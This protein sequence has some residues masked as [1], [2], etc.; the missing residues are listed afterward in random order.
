[1][2]RKWFS[3]IVVMLIVLITLVGCGAM[4]QPET[5]EVARHA[6]SKAGWAP[7]EPAVDYDTAS[8]WADVDDQEIAY[9]GTLAQEVTVQERLIIRNADLSIVV[10]DTEET[11]SAIEALVNGAGGWVVNSNAYQYGDYKRGSISVRVPAEELDSFIKEIRSLAHEV[12]SQNISG[13]DVTEEF[14]DLKAQLENLQ[15]TADRVRTFLDETKNVEEA[16]AVNVELSR[17]E[18]D[19]ER[20]IARMNYLEGSAR[21]SAVSIE[22]T[23][24]EL[25][26]PITIGK[27][28]PQGTAKDAIEALVE[29]LQWFIDALIV[30][31]IYLLPMALI[32]FGP[33][34]LFLR[35]L[36]KRRAKLRT[37]EQT[38]THTEP[39]ETAQS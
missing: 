7:G 11:I 3:A 27:W 20:I 33:I 1:M 5:V 2:S 37:A 28:E 13:Q 21:F 36:L 35:W 6:E 29:S 30:I 14:V 38:A 17:L 18:G 25:N 26:Q 4:A 16:L 39:K 32:T 31:V 22:I 12:T 23:P 34:Y 10:D 8:N 9:S 24:D 15:A 19:I